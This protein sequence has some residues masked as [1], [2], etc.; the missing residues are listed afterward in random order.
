[1]RSAFEIESYSRHAQA[2]NPA[3]RSLRVY[4]PASGGDLIRPV[5]I[6][7]SDRFTYVDMFT[8][9]EGF[10]GTFPARMEEEAQNLGITDL[11][12]Q[13]YGR[14]GIITFT[15]QH[16]Q[17]E[18]PRE[19]RITFYAADAEQFWPPEFEDGYDV[20]ILKDGPFLWGPD[21]QMRQLGIKMPVDGFLISDNRIAYILSPEWIG[22]EETPFDV[23]R[24][25]Y[26]DKIY[27]KA[28]QESLELLSILFSL[29]D[30]FWDLRNTRPYTWYRNTTY[31][32]HSSYMGENEFNE[33][34]E[35]MR[36]EYISDIVPKF[37]T[38]G[39]LFRALPE[40]IRN[41]LKEKLGEY[42]SPKHCPEET[43]LFQK[44]IILI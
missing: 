13:D 19:R 32:K 11:H 2:V 27:R 33:W 4:Y 18:K 31:D 15:Y 26:P 3:G 10:F 6:T 43:E 7:N 22:Y 39:Q 21:A 34:M 29:D 42:F 25:I 16:Q 17:D 1:M 28:R 14:N 12:V 24:G 8:L 38:A 37:D 20:L 44:M 41:E 30:I 36:S 23:H 5:T 40:D 9:K 35:G